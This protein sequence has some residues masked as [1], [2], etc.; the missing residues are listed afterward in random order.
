MF[1]SKEK[2]CFA[3]FF[4]FEC[5][6]C[7]GYFLFSWHLNSFCCVRC[8]FTDFPLQQSCHL[9]KSTNIFCGPSIFSLDST[10]GRKWEGSAYKFLNPS[11]RKA[12]IRRPLDQSPAGHSS[13]TCPPW[14]CVPLNHRF[15]SRTRLERSPHPPPGGGGSFGK[16]LIRKVVPSDHSSFD[17]SI[18]CLKLSP[19]LCV[20]QGPGMWWTTPSTRSSPPKTPLRPPCGPDASGRPECWQGVTNYE[21]G[22]W[23]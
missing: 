23:I 13:T 1:S 9:F 6:A 14:P 3:I 5:F 19:W 22:I 10:R 15:L 8:W 7:F 11:L 16:V 2:T 17:I 20:P 21:I 4:I 12:L 18:M